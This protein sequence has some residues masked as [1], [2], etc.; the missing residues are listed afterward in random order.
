MKDRRIIQLKKQMIEFGVKSNDI[1]EFFGWSWTYTSE[2]LN[3]IA[4]A[5][6]EQINKVKDA[7]PGIAKRK[8]ELE[9]IAA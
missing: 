2:L 3:G 7:L 5:S 6:D 1:K 4:Y 8:R 9:E